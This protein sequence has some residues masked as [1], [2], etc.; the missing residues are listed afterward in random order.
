MPFIYVPN[1][2]FQTF[3]NSM[4]ALHEDDIECSTSGGFCKF[5]QACNNV[6]QDFQDLVVTFYQANPKKSFSYELSEEDMLIDG[7]RVDDTSETCYI[8]I[9][10][11]GLEQSDSTWYIGAI[12]MDKYYTVYD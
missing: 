8:A 9:F 2:D 3:A 4:K 10:D 11:S 1:A 12:F 7:S 5:N 6:R